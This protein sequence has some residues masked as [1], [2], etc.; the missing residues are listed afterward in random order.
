MSLIGQITGLRPTKSGIPKLTIQIAVESQFDAN[1][2]VLT[3]NTEVRVSASAYSHDAWG[4]A[5]FL[6][7]AVWDSWITQLP[8]GGKTTWEMGLP[9]SPVHLQI[10]EE[11]RDGRD[12]WLMAHSTFTAAAIPNTGTTNYGSFMSGML[13][14][15][16]RSAGTCIYK[17]A[18]SDW[19][20]LRK[21]LGY[22]ERMLIEIPLHISAKK[23]MAK[24]LE[25]LQAASD[26]FAEDR[27][28]ETL[29]SCYRI[30]EY[31][32]HKV[33]VNNPDQNGFEKL[34]A[35]LEDTEKRNKLKMLM[36]HLCQVFHLGRHEPGK[37]HVVVDRRDAEYAL[38]LSQATLAYLAKHWAHE[39]TRSQ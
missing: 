5:A 16:S 6:G 32:A 11:A 29:A 25:H 10:I 37:E 28:E 7:F 22:G 18:R 33:G 20:Q 21:E 27:S 19:L 38:I 30:F 15:P 31:L 3:V 14:D 17:I 8:K 24:A 4:S 34:L 13:S 1:V 35:S 36:H 12:I 26:H 9:L 23:G 39:P 2:A